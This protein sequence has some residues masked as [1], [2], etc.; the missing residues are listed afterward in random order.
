MF[1]NKGG[2]ANIFTRI[3][4][5]FLFLFFIIWINWAFAMSNFQKWIIMEKFKSRQEEL[6]FDN[7]IGVNSIDA[8]DLLKSNSRIDI[9]EN[10]KS[11]VVKKR[12]DLEKQNMEIAEKIENLQFQL[13]SLEKDII[14]IKSEMIKISSQ[15]VNTTRN[16]QKKRQ[17]IEYTKK[18]VETN[19]EILR[20]YIA[21][22]YKKGN[23]FL[24]KWTIDNLK[25]I[26]L[27]G[28]NIDNVIND[29]YFKEIISV[30]WRQLIE[31]HRR[32]LFDLYVEK[33]GLEKETTDLKRLKRVFDIKKNIL[34]EKKDFKKNVLE[35]SKG[36]EDLYKKYIQE[37]IEIEKWLKLKVSNER[38]KFFKT[39][40]KILWDYNC[41]FIKLKNLNLEQS[42]L[43]EKCFNLNK[44]ISLEA[45]LEENK[46]EYDDTKEAY[47]IFNWPVMPSKGISAYYHDV[48]YQKMFNSEH[49][50]IDILVD[51]S[52]SIQAPLD[53]YVISIKK[54][55][56]TSYSY[57]ALKHS[58]WYVTVYGHVSESF[59]NKYDYV[60]SG[61]I[62]WKTWWTFWTKWAWYVT[63]WPHLHFEIFD[64]NRWN[65][66]PLKYL[67]VSYL[68]FDTILDSYKLDF[69]IDF[70]ERTWKEYEEKKK[71]T[72]KIFSLDWVNEIE[73]QKSLLLKYARNDF[74]NWNMWIEES[75]RWNI[76]PTFMMCIWLA[77]SSLW[78]NLKTSY[79]VWNVWNVD[80]GW[81]WSLKTPRAGVWWI[82]NTLNNK[83]LINYNKISQLSWYWRIGNRP[84]YATSPLNWHRNIIKCMSVIK[85]QYIKDD[86]N[87]RTY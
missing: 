32:F 83:Y 41:E 42:G 54:P 28:D 87:F 79:N 10:I 38:T 3:I 31:K 20:E 77:E 67:D 5:L 59:V 86:Y 2:G 82:W 21:Y 47:N 73:R 9:Y 53:W 49:E 33:K 81:T 50:W 75:I 35:I 45:K 14:S 34:E 39:T 30:A 16:I 43:T 1:N 7:S 74:N 19:S 71:I 78:R 55:F 6:I 48:W 23:L 15:I 66:D 8:L 72:W 76:D 62:I 13:G 27:S 56:D 12:K 37:K 44:I 80:S 85:D 61:E 4:S 17:K 25:A 58:N 26:L 29:I 70:K 24:D 46:I 52:T 51:Q 65:I 84:I 63:T 18:E 57:I 64:E 69:F 22:I 36:K 40:K 68:D 60:K 11:N